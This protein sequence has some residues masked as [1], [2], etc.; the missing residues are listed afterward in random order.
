MTIILFMAKGWE[1]KSVEEQQSLASQPPITEEERVRLSQ[2]HMEK[3]RK[4]QALNMSRAR[5][6]QQMEKATN[7]RYRTMLQQELSYLES[8]MKKLG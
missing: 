3:V 6:A 2:E 8:E 4:Q 1:S 7:D 5:V